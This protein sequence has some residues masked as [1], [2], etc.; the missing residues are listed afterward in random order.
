MVYVLPAGLLLGLS[1]SPK[2][3]SRLCQSTL[4]SEPPSGGLLKFRF[5][6]QVSRYATTCA[7]RVDWEVRQE[8]QIQRARRQEEKNLERSTSEEFMEGMKAVELNEEGVTA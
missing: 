4:C 8:A 6:Q 2:L 5:F 3:T 7:N 1:I